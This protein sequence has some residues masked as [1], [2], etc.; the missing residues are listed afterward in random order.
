VCVNVPSLWLGAFTI[1]GAVQLS[2]GAVLAGFYNLIAAFTV[3][4]RGH[5]GSV[6]SYTHFCSLAAYSRHRVGLSL[7]MPK[8]VLFLIRV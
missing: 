1:A 4:R 3:N 6:A 5:S 2:G 8:N 7:L